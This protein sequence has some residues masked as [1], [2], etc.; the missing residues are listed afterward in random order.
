[1]LVLLIQLQAMAYV[2]ILITSFIPAACM[3][4]RCTIVVRTETIGRPLR[5]VATTRT[6]WSS[7]VAASAQARAT[8]ASTTVE[9]CVASLAPNLDLFAN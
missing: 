1:M 6:T 7:A 9:W 3:V 8:A 4:R 2:P 5:S